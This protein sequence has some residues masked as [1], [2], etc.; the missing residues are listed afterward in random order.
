MTNKSSERIERIRVRLEKALSPSF[1]QIDDDS[2]LHVG[3]AG[4]K[5]GL[6]HFT[7]TVGASSFGGKSRLE[8][9]RLVYDALGSMMQTDIHALRIVFQG[10]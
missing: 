3:H 5:S 4:A 1:L 2:H 10:S 8:K 7:V 6:G 9:H